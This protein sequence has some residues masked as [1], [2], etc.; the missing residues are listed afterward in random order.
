MIWESKTRGSVLNFKGPYFQNDL[1]LRLFC[2][3]PPRVCSVVLVYRYLLVLNTWQSD[4]R[5]R[6]ACVHSSYRCILTLTLLLVCSLSHLKLT[7]LKMGVPPG[8]W[9]RDLPALFLL[10][11]KEPSPIALD[12]FFQTFWEFGIRRELIFFSLHLMNF[13]ELWKFTVWKTFMKLL[14]VLVIVTII[15]KRMHSK[16]IHKSFV[17]TVKSVVTMTAVHDWSL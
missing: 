3:G 17:E 1:E 6:V 4:Y 13:T 9:T 12:F 8:I 14:Q 15:L 16:V 11:L 7:P 5:R 10:T 2:I